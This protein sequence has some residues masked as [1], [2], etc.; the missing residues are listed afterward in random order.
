M[1]ALGFVPRHRFMYIPEGYQG[2]MRNFLKLFITS[3]T[4][5]RKFLNTSFSLIDHLRSSFGIK[6]VLIYDAN[7][8]R[9]FRAETQGKNV[10]T[11]AHPDTPSKTI[12]LIHVNAGGTKRSALDL[13]E[14]QQTLYYKACL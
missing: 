7:D 10:M 1:P 2:N 12:H 9:Q 14:H 13:R 6:F 3:A 8:G 4:A 11:V 5:K